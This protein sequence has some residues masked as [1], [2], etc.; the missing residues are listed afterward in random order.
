MKN[1]IRCCIAEILHELKEKKEVTWP[2][3]SQA[4]GV[5]VGRLKS[6]SAGKTPM[7]DWQLVAVAKFFKCEVTYLLYGLKEIND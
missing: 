3:I 1:K 6:W 5:P 2:E 7:A 4:T